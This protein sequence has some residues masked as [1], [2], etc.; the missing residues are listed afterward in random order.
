MSICRSK[1]QYFAHRVLLQRVMRRKKDFKI[2]RLE[3][4]S[5]Y[6]QKFLGI[7]PDKHSQF[8]AEHASVCIDAQSH[9]HFEPH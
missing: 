8:I 3:E 9:E 2:Q 1:L 5:G 6:G 7:P 4:K